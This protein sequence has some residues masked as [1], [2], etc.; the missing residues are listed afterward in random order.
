MAG[1]AAIFSVNVAVSIRP[2][3]ADDVAA[4]T[5]IDARASDFPW[6]PGQIQQSIDV[7]NGHD[8]VLIIES[9][10]ELVGFV[11]FN[12][13]LDEGS[14]HN[15]AVHPEYQRQGLASKLLRKAIKHMKGKGA[16]RCF[17]DVRRS[18]IA[19]VAFYTGL[20]FQI[21]GERRNY[22]R[23]WAGREDALLMSKLL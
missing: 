16:E 11:F 5:D 8:Q 9:E 14:I 21:E 3:I 15:I 12:L 17:L 10:S 22:Y 23:A 2:A 6:S 13:V 18:N 1:S 4:I 19:A 7:D 20:G